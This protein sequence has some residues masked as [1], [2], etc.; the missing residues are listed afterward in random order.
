MKSFSR[1]PA[2][3]V[4][5]FC[6]YGPIDIA[7]RSDGPLQGLTFAVKDLFDIAGL[8]TGAGSPDWLRSHAVPAATA[9]AVERLFDAGAR[10]IGKTHTD[11]LA[12]SLAGQNAHFGTPLNVAAPGRIPG[13]SSSGS[14]AAT[15]AGLVDFAIGSD[16]G[17]SVRLPASFC[18]LYGMRPTHG[19]IPLNGVMPLAPSYD[20]VGWFARDPALL[21]R[22]GRVLLGESSSP[23]HHQP[24]RLLLARDLFALAH[25]DAAAALAPGIARLERLFGPA[26][27]VDVT[28]GEV[29]GW[30][31]AFR[32]I[33]SAEVWATHGAW[34][35]ACRPSFGPGIAERFAAAERLDPAEVAAARTLR[36]EI[37]RRLEDILGPGGVL[38]LPSAQGIAPR[39]DAGAAE[40]ELFRAGALA[41]LCPA[42]HAGLPQISLP[43]GRLDGGPVGLSLIGPSC[44]D[45]TLLDLACVLDKS[46]HAL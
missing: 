15:A 18:G 12:W 22:V 45:E 30:R 25:E 37:R 20:T 46:R 39:R 34:V 36:V 1:L 33:Q 21:A 27:A 8:P 13:G 5:A 41:L 43:L 14:A 40:M 10:C 2:D 7:A 38:V 17:G 42:G 26:E 44:A 19:R 32:L 24:L 35:K 4:G 16:T 6:D 31:D 9:P 23:Q 3:S 28:Q 11:E 29:A